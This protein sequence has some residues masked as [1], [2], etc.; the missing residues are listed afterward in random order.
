MEE[1]E[2]KY[3]PKTY[4]ENVMKGKY[5]DVGKKLAEL[6]TREVCEWII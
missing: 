1:F 3:L 4:E 6:T 2:R 5:V